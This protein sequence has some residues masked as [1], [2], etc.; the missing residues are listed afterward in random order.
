M[1][2]VQA[3]PRWA[4]PLGIHL[5]TGRTWLVLHSSSIS[6]GNVSCIFVSCMSHTGC[7]RSVG[8][9]SAL[10]LKTVVKSEKN[11]Q[12]PSQFPLDVL[13]VLKSWVQSQVCTAAKQSRTKRT[14]SK[15][16]APSRGSLHTVPT[17]E[18]LCFGSEFDRDVCRADLSQISSGLLVYHYHEH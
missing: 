5:W 9:F 6:G 12:S 7:G 16:S 18:M 1:S 8:D 13:R 11:S 14:T 3:L 4:L 10:W 2:C 17:N 15:T